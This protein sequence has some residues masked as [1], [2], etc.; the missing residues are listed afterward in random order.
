[1]PSPPRTRLW[2]RA[3]QVE[4][5][6]LATLVLAVTVVVGLA[7]FAWTTTGDAAR[8]DQATRD[9]TALVAQYDQIAAALA[10]V[11]AA[12]TRDVLKPSTGDQRVLA[13]SSS[14]LAP[15]LASLGR[16]P[17]AHPAMSSSLAADQRDLD[18]AVSE[19]QDAIRRLDGPRVTAIDARR[20]QPAIHAMHDRIAAGSAVASRA[21]TASVAR[22]RA[23]N[24][25]LGLVAVATAAL[26]VL[27]GTMLFRMLLLRRRLAV[28]HEREVEWH[29]TAA[30]RDSLTGLGNHRSF[31]ED[32][33]D[34]V[35]R[36]ALLSLLL[37][38]LDGLKV[39][40]DQQGHTAGDELLVKLSAALRAVTPEGAA[41]YRVGGDE[42]A[43]LVENDTPPASILAALADACAETPA[44]QPVATAGYAARSAGMSGGDLCH[45][46]D[47]ALITA[48]QDAVRERGYS[49]D[50]ER[51]T[52]VAANERTEL[53]E[54]L[55]DPAA[56]AP[57]YQPIFD[58]RDGRVV[59]YEALTR[60]AAA[61]R[62]PQEWF[63]LAQRHGKAVE[64]ETAAL[65]TAIATPGRPAGT[66]LSLNIS[67]DVLLR[68]P[69]RLGLPD[70][71]AGIIIEVTE[72]ALVTDG[73]DLERALHDL[74]A[75]GARIAVD[76]A[77]AGYAGFGQLVRV[78]PD[79]I[80]L[81]RSLIRDVDSTPTKAAVLRAFIGYARDTGATICAEGIETEGELRTVT[82]LGATLG[83][84][85][86]LG[87]PQPEWFGSSIGVGPAQPITAANVV[88][89]PHRAA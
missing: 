56:L 81:D 3:P 63:D 71:L 72:N 37:I 55:D 5:R 69:E 79:I 39:V 66:T 70:D 36:E 1:M 7:W 77:G 48:K 35:A 87:R 9:S 60:F 11:Q 75:R 76:D 30:R 10:S 58:L 2:S 64:L 82:M 8:A 67:P 41:A 61:H 29:R 19:M 73:L 54:L 62:A 22:S 45:R 26:A 68:G 51:P 52:D 18:G 23:A 78:R 47:L 53:A 14:R 28:A 13:Q 25:R 88:P 24:D 32:M 27:A 86:L 65:R 40:N 20:L 80:K 12:E 4:A 17:G 49:P 16:M 59:S 34:A 38:D 74:R 46:A 85:Y 84:G 15:L 21:A 57:V 42:F 83:Q 33:Q 31:L 43:I 50:L 6:A 89:F 44:P